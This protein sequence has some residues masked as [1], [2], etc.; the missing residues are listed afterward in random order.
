MLLLP[1]LVLGQT[2]TQNYVRT[3]VY[4]DSTST[5]D[6]S[7]AKAT[8]TYYDGLGRPIQQVAGKASAS[9][10]DIITHIEYDA[11]GR[12]VKEYLPY[13]TTNTGLEFLDNAGGTTISFYS[14]SSDYENTQNPY[15]EKLLEASPLGRVL[16]QA[17]PG[18]DWVITGTHTMNFTYSANSAA[19]NVKMLTAIAIW[20]NTTE[21]YEPL[22][23]A[24]S[25]YTAGELY[26]T[27]TTDENGQ[28]TTEFKNKEGQ[29]VLKRSVNAGVNHDTYYVYDNYGN[30]TYVLPP[31]AEG[32]LDLA[33]CYYYKYDRRNRLVEKKIPGKSWE[34]IV[35]DNLDRVVA[36]GP[37]YSP[38]ADGT[39]GWLRTYYDTFNRVCVTGW[40][41]ASDITTDTRK[42]LQ[43]NSDTPVTL[44][45]RT[46]TID[47]IAIGYEDQYINPGL[48]LLTINYYD[49]Y[50]WE[51][52]LFPPGATYITGQNTKVKGQLTGT[53]ERVLTS[54]AETLAQITSTLYDHKYR[55]IYTLTK[56]YLGGYTKV[57]T[58]YDFDG[59][60]LSVETTHKRATGGDSINVK[61]EFTYTAEDRL[62]T[63]T[64]KINNNAPELLVHNTYNELGQ[65]RSKKV[66]G[67][68]VTGSAALQKIDFTYNIRGWLKGINNIENLEVE[69]NYPD[70]FAFRVNYTET[71]TNNINGNVQQLYNGNIAETY[72]RSASD[73]I[74]RAYGYKYDKLNRLLDAYYQMPDD[75]A[76]I[77]NSYYEHVEYDKNGN[78]TGLQR[79]G[80]YDDPFILIGIDNLN[81]VYDAADKN[82][83]LKVI[84]EPPHPSGFSDSP[85]NDVDDYTYDDFGNM[86]S[87]RNKYIQEITYNHLNLPVNIA[88][89]SVGTRS[90]SYLYTASGVKLA[91]TV[92]EPAM[93]GVPARNDVTEYF[94]GFQY[95]KGFLQYFPTAEGYVEH[96]VVDGTS[97]YNYVYQY[98]DHLGNNRVSYAVDPDSNV[99]KIKEESHYYPFGLKHW[100]Y[101]NAEYS[102]QG[103]NAR[104]S[105]MSKPGGGGDPF[106]TN[107]FVKAD[108]KYKYN[109]KEWQDELGLNMYDYGA[110]QYDPALGR[111]FA[112]DP[113]AETSRRWSPY[114][115]C[116]NNPMVFVDPDGMEAD[117][118]K[119]DK[120][121]SFFSDNWEGAWASADVQEAEYKRAFA[122]LG[123]KYDEQDDGNGEGENTNQGS[124][125]ITLE[126]EVQ[127]TSSESSVSQDPPKV[128]PAPNPKSMDPKYKVE[129]KQW[130]KINGRW[131][132]HT[133]REI[134]EWD[135]KK[136]EVEV[137]SEKEHKGGY[138][139]EN[140]NRQISK[141]VKGRQ[142]NS[143]WKA[144][145]SKF[146]NLL[147]IPFLFIPDAVRM[148]TN[149]NSF[150]IEKV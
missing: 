125:T 70:L 20:N 119:E 149:P 135:S 59:T 121:K 112:V 17:A 1:V 25:N 37:V 68:D 128:Y 133:K 56:N 29:V 41:P 127:A 85:D 142:P 60:P 140:R 107:Q 101:N 93:M 132:I 38:F 124:E 10:K 116:Y 90:I 115:Y 53:W 34:Y 138:D 72:W 3:C 73:N 4:K 146:F 35:Y 106:P 11:W 99:L 129:N 113:L 137:Y 109:A 100:N 13:A 141:P 120:L 91:K 111:W 33:L 48:K 130:K 97:F 43:N 2:T 98:K 8:V 143:G 7:K 148:Q 75:I 88:F 104:V 108:Y 65:L 12:Q 54:P 76:P 31:L 95:F 22:F 144:K 61:E 42:T 150:E 15:N 40:T 102:F 64:H 39:I 87:D 45:R 51:G 26:K 50:D 122:N 6:P 131:A 23:Q 21:I 5:S 62:L 136:G 114:A 19:D 77:R 84:D 49:D 44:L 46:G 147:K 9:G 24:S 55:P 16:K 27:V 78:I 58:S 30:L 66:G 105:L 32:N 57:L 28:P 123:G 52:S 82:K 81:Y 86:V 14:G 145:N 118:V 94:G 47:N 80:D 126:G 79:F 67:A 96:T 69:S 89:Y 74:K 71:L 18:A 134:L 63:H 103:R 83:L 117:S 110:R 139:P 92:R 36:A